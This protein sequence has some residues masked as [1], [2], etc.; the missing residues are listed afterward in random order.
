MRPHS[1]A[2]TPSGTSLKKWSRFSSTSYASRSVLVPTSS[3]SRLEAGSSS[4]WLTALI[5]LLMLRYLMLLPSASCW[6]GLWMKILPP[7]V[8]AVRHGCLPSYLPTVASPSRIWSFNRSW[9]AG[10]SGI[11]NGVM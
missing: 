8:A 10:T 11:V 3:T 2:F 9:N 6:Y 7:L 1:M 4:P 5:F